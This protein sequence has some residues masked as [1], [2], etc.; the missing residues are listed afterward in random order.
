MGKRSKGRGKGRKP[1]APITR[2]N[3][4]AKRARR[5][6]S[7]EER[8][9]QA[10]EADAE[11]P[12]EPDDESEDLDEGRVSD[13]GDGAEEAESSEPGDDDAD[14]DHADDEADDASSESEVGRPDG[15]AWAQPLVK[16]EHKW[17]WLETRLLFVA[18]LALTFVL[19]LFFALRGMKESLD[20]QEAAG[21]IFRAIVGAGVLGGVVR[22]ATRN[23]GMK[24]MHRNVATVVA[25]LIGLATAKLWR[26]VGI[27]YFAGVFDWLQEGSTLTLMGGLK[28]ISTRLT[29]TVALIGASLAAAVGGHINID[30]VVRIIPTRVRKPVAILGSVATAMVCLAASWGLFD[31]IAVAEYH[32]GA[33]ET[34]GAKVSA[35]T[36]DLGHQFFIWR[37]QA[38]LDIGAIP[39]VVVGKRWNAEDRMNG[40]QWNE[41]LDSGGFS[42]RFG[43]AEVD[44]IR[45][46]DEDLD[47]PRLPLVVL[48]GGEARGML[49]HGMDLIFP[50]GFLMI[51]LRFLLRALLLLAGHIDVKIEAEDE[52]DDDD[53]VGAADVAPE[54]AS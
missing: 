19:C 51:G 27:E 28:G 11:E 35:V 18:L 13:P 34:A 25:V 36:E 43:K 32:V 41:W 52:D 48:P 30:V 16:L 39:N 47:L 50:L 17:T 21:T 42:E 15:A 1:R 7:E 26:G 20:A 5:E 29:M 22:L 6:A 10:A 54:E 31:H 49:L 9:A 12:D 45:A 14:A 2:R 40:R 8:A 46:I 24:E 44:A 37:K 53:D 23:R 33:D 4:D 38:G 3:V